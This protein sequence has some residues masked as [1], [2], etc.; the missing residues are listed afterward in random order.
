MKPWMWGAL[1]MFLL[2]L[3][4]IVFGTMI[5]QMMSG[6]EDETV[7]DLSAPAPTP[8]PPSPT[9]EAPADPTPTPVAPAVDTDP[10]LPPMPG[11]G[12]DAPMPVDDTP[13]DVSEED[14]NRVMDELIDQCGLAGWSEMGRRCDGPRCNTLLA[15]APPDDGYPTVETLLACPVWKDNWGSFAEMT[16]MRVSCEDGVE[17]EITSLGPTTG[18]I[19]DMGKDGTEV[20]DVESTESMTARA[21]ASWGR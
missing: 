14:F 17:L 11:S 10:A 3:A 7:S 12:P 9:A 1:A 19:R 4:G 15:M 21:C 16:A 20:V 5:G 18:R 13:D 6:P 2:L 8:P